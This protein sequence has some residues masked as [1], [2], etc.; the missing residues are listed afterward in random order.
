[1]N[2]EHYFPSFIAKD[3]NELRDNKNT[4]KQLRKYRIFAGPD[5]ANV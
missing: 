2:K 5:D 1:M 3:V 4:R